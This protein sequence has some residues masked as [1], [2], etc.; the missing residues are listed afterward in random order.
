VGQYASDKNL[1]PFE[2]DIGDQAE[3]VAADVENASFFHFVNAWKNSSQLSEILEGV[4]FDDSVP[5]F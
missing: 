4:A 3:F 2:I 1:V 5:A